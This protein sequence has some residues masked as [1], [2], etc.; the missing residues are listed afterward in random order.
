[1]DVGLTEA[2]GDAD[3]LGRL[4]GG[5]VVGV[6]VELGRIGGSEVVPV[7][8]AEDVGSVGGD[9]VGVAVELGRIG[10]SEVVPVGVDVSDGVGVT[11]VSLASH[12]GGSPVLLQ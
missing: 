5:D 8:V 2:L 12:G 7:G 9:V 11:T 1:M 10:G 6:A 4:V 3:E